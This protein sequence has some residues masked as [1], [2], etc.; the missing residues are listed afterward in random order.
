M[1][2]SDKRIK[3]LKKLQEHIGITFCNIKILNTAFL[4]PSF[5]N[6]KGLSSDSNQRLEFL[7]DAVLELVIS[8]YL[9]NNYPKL[10]EGQMTKIRALIV[11]EQSLAKTAKKL[12]LGQYLLLGRGEKATGGGEKNSIL[13][14]TYESLIGAIYLERGYKEANYFIVRTLKNIILK[15]VKGESEQDF[16]TILQEMLQKKSTKPINYKTIKEK[17]PDHN[18]VFYVNVLWND[19]SLGTGIGTTKKQAEQMA[20]KN[21]LSN[22]NI[23]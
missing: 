16:K 2:I 3:Q 8:H 7:G 21:A 6:E 17:G 9:F 11:C 13:A 19:K 23:K 22:L 4:H 5:I 14:D 15:A 20:A 12:L 18:K 1:Q 10:T